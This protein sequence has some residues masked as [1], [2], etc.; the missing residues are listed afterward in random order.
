MDYRV[1]PPFRFVGLGLVSLFLIVASVI[2][3]VLARPWIGVALEAE[4]S[5]AL[6]V[7]SVAPDAPAP[8]ILKGRGVVAL[9]G[10]GSDPLPLLPTDL[11]ED[12]DKLETT[13]RSATFWNAKA[14]SMPA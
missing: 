12:P 3:A 13:R 8:G 10:Q 2:W 6:R 4:A 1:R 14:R 7:I 9:G 5:G 11:V